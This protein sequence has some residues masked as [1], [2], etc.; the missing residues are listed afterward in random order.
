MS[1]RVFVLVVSIL[2]LSMTCLLDFGTVPTVWYYFSIYYVL[3]LYFYIDDSEDCTFTITIKGDGRCEDKIKENA[4]RVKTILVQEFGVV[5][6]HV[7]DGSVVI[8]LK[9]VDGNIISR[10][11]DGIRRGQFVRLIEELFTC[12]EANSSIPS[13]HWSVDFII[14]LDNSS[15][16]MKGKR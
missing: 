15:S 5:P 4:M 3:F 8:H 1:G 7:T 6:T 10:L 12:H 2:P 11:T 9:S 16:K 13:G 14:E